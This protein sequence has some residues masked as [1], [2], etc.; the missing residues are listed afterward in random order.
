M[1]TRVSKLCR[2]I[3][4]QAM[5]DLDAVITPGHAAG[6][7]SLGMRFESLLEKVT[8]QHISRIS[9]SLLL[10]TF[11]AVR[12]WVK[13]GLINQIGVAEGYRGGL[14][15]GVRIGFSI[16]DVEKCCNSVVQEDHED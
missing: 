4:N 9:E 5:I 6:G 2:G 10:C 16:A 12:V 14:R 15:N 13:D 8:P 1:R 11:G 7:I 3:K